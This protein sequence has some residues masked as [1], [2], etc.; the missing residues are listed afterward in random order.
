MALDRLLRH[1]QAWQF[2]QLFTSRARPE[3]GAIFLAQRRVYILPTRHGVTFG[4]ALLLMLIGSIN[5]GLSLGYVLTF[6]LAG[7]GLVSMVHTY[8]NLAHLYVSAGRVEP[9]FAGEMALFPIHIENR[10]DFE[11]VAI[12]LSASDVTTKCD[13]N[14]RATAVAT[15]GIPTARRGRLSLPRVTVET[16]YPVGLFRAWSYV[17]PD[18]ETL[19]YPRPDNAQLPPAQLIPDTGAALSAGIGTDDF[20]GLRPY[21]PTDSPRHIAWK[22]VAHG[23]D[24]LTKVF[25]GRGAE[26]LWLDYADLLDGLDVEQRLSRL[27]GWVLLA[28]R[29]GYAYGMLLPGKTI[30]PAHGP[31]HR[32]ECLKALALY[33]PRPSAR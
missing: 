20:A 21:Q 3:P 2:W 33:E 15:L 16:R 31:A 19:V 8:R 32:D 1:S 4:V 28:E 5:Y 12:C 10:H 6:L 22:S 17:Q 30:R 14:R 25:A 24:V 26:E 27:A 11:R 9:V 29:E 7:M 13:V 23:N 18:V